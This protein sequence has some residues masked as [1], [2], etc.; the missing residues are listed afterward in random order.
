MSIQITF[1]GNIAVNGRVS[2]RTLGTTYSSLQHSLERS[3]LDI[4]RSGISKNERMGASDYQFVEFYLSSTQEGSYIA[5]FVESG[6][7]LI[8]VIDNV[9]R[10]VIDPY[11]VAMSDGE[12]AQNQYLQNAQEDRL[13]ISLDSAIPYDELEERSKAGNIQTKS[14]AG[15]SIA[16]NIN[17]AL[18][19][20]R[21]DPGESSITITLTGTESHEFYFNKR[22]SQRFSKLVS[23]KDLGPL[24]K[25]EAYLVSLDGKSLKRLRGHI[26][27]VSTK[28]ES[29]L[30]LLAIS[31]KVLIAHEL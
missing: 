17:K 9:I 23:L 27:H 21:K 28:K 24:V 20:V 11:E 19:P 31:Q 29:N 10:N 13:A 3:Y 18:I 22:I 12:I 1:D 2:M 14:Y 26:R 5:K 25:Y 4:S 16:S 15:K 30:V 8:E 7:K 6:S